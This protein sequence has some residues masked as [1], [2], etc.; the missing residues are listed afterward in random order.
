MADEHDTTVDELA[1]LRAADPVPPGDPRFHDRPLPP[2]AERH[3]NRLLHT[4]DRPS[5]VPR[6]A[7]SAATAAVV[8]AVAA[9]LLLSGPTT[10]PAVAAPRPL[11]LETGSAR[12]PLDRLADRA[13]TSGARLRQ[14]THVQTWSLSMTAD[15]KAP[16]T[17][18]TER[19]VRWRADGS[20][21]ELVV[22]TD[23]RHPGEPVI[24]DTGGTPHTVEDGHVL[25][26]TTY[27][28]SWSDAPPQARPPHD[29]PAL[30]AYLT[31]TA[32][33][34]DAAPTTPQLLDAV[35]ELLDHWTPGARESAALARVLADAEDLRPAGAVTDRLGRQGQAY[36]Y[37]GDGLRR[38]VVLDP[39]T[40]AL[41]GMETTF[42]TDEPDYGVKAGDVMDYSAWLR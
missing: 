34:G 30:L 24:V 29:P 5:R 9:A 6:W 40:G 3:L 33:I 7:W 35:R 18:P 12:V 20:R 31:E 17:L 42:T 1:L 38:M 22:A 14:G 23:P 26:R 2:D 11:V 25:S 15:G 27:P 39:A 36:V 10:A 8:G 21:T 32:R 41:L 28:P 16:I 37:D 4:R 19:L 13:A